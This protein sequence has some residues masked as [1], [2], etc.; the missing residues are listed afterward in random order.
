MIT[1]QQSKVTL[2]SNFHNNY[3][4]MKKQLHTKQ[5]FTIP[6]SKSGLLFWISAGS[7][8][9]TYFGY[10]MIISLLARLIPEKRKPKEFYP[11]VTLLIAAHNEEKIIEMKILNSLSLDY[12]KKCLQILIVAD[13]SD[14][15]TPDIVKKY[16]N[17]NIEL[18]YEPERRGKMAAINRSIPSARGDIIVFSDANNLYQSNTIKELTIPFC[19]PTIGA[20]S[21]AKTIQNTGSNIGESEGLY[22]KYESYIKEQE[23]KLGSC[24]GVAG[25]ILAIRKSAYQAPPDNIINDDFYL[26][27]LIV[28]QG[29]RI[30]YS[31]KAI[32]TESVSTSPEGEI[33]RRKRINA[34]RY[35]AIFHSMKILPFKRP[36]VV[37]QVISHKFMRPLVP[38]FMIGVFLSNIILVFRTRNQTRRRKL[39]PSYSTNI[40]IF[41]A[42]VLFYGL[43]WLGNSGNRIKKDNKLG[44]LLYLPTFL[45]NSNIAA[46]KGFFQYMKGEQTHIWERVSRE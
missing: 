32:S 2:P 9:Y 10:P 1:S 23:S 29:Y 19:D 20:V 5:N 21:G 12:P 13:G 43:A 46:L 18:L 16:S 4:Q 35:Q 27:M 44:K 8:L 42:Q 3:I 15:N 38:F 45:Y 31:P 6:I 26:A 17:Q 24:I 11:S 30:A 41:V 7:I 25:E 22:W 28:K 14:D 40:A 33:I 36:L 39:S 34:G 37:W